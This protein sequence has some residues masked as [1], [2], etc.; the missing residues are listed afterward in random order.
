MNFRVYKVVKSVNIF[1]R[2]CGLITILQ[3]KI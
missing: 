3:L 2:V 1:Y